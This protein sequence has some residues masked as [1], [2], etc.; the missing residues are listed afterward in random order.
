M[1]KCLFG[2]FIR[3]SV[4]LITNHIVMSAEPSYLVSDDILI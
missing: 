1:K 3:E 4:L 2:Y